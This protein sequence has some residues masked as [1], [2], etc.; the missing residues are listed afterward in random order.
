MNKVDAER[1][2]FIK[3]Y[4]LS[5]RSSGDYCREYDIKYANK[6]FN[7]ILKKCTTKK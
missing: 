4:I 2:E 1:M 3:N 6:L 5:K 7:K